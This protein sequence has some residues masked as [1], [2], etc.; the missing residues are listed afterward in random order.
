MGT[1]LQIA[2]RSI[3]T[4][5]RM[6]LSGGESNRLRR[7]TLIEGSTSVTCAEGCGRSEPSS[8]RPCVE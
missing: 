5:P 1:A 8:I 7:S 6:C 2:A 4:S 3:V